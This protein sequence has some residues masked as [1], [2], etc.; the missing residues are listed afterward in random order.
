MRRNTLPIVLG[1][2]IVLVA[3]VGIAILAQPAPVEAKEANVIV[4][5]VG[6]GGFKLGAT[7]EQ[8]IEALGMPIQLSEENWLQ[9]R[10][11]QGLI[12]CLIDDN[13][14][15]FELRFDEGFKGRTT[16]GIG[17]GT[18]LK[19][20]LAA[21]GEPSSRVDKEKEAAKKLVWS[22]KGILIWFR[23]N[24]VTQIVVFKPH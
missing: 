21:Y 4:E 22:S 14:G 8:L 19:K 16:A 1:S 15:A 20:A 24:K 12:H 7:R 11:R 9:W 13:R 3:A 5:G 18:S 2:S 10:T 23:G 6:W 17:L